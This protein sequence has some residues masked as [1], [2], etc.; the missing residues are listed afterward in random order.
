[1]ESNAVRLLNIITAYLQ[2]RYWRRFGSRLELESH[3]QNLWRKQQ[4]R[5]TKDSPLYRAY[6]DKKLSDFPIMNKKDMMDNFDNLNTKSLKKSD[7]L[8][9]ALK[10]EESRDFSP[11]VGQ[12]SVGL[13]S[14]T[15]GNRGLFLADATERARWAGI[16]LAKAL[17]KPLP[18]AQKI[19]LFLRANNNLYTTLTSK[20][21]QFEFFD[22]QDELTNH[23]QRLNQYRPSI[24]VS[25]PSMLRM[26]A[27]EAQKGRLK[28]N[29]LRIFSAAEVLDPID[30]AYISH[31]FKQKVH[32]LYQ[33]TEGFLG[34][35]CAHGTIHL[36][37][38]FVIVEKEWID[39]A[40]RK[41]IPIITD[42]ERHTQPIVRYRLND[43]LTERATPCP[44]GSPHI[45]LEQIEGRADD[46]FY[47]KTKSGEH[48]AVFPDYLRRRILQADD[49]IEEYSLRQHN[50]DELE[51]RLKKGNQNA[52]RE[53][54]ERFFT[55]QNI[56]APAL[57][58]EM[59]EDHSGTRKM[60]RVERLFSPN[61]ADVI[62]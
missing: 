49:A 60:K 61:I 12:V 31:V 51:I 43:V 4:A 7:C 16:I 9:V 21:I 23:V 27:T 1:M 36:N 28:I 20:K 52:V 45:A 10:S 8:D 33:C 26:L 50:E 59:Y 19:A 38:D 44:C 55:E 40:K 42:L 46:I 6:A 25:P 54:F 29:P 58:F 34:A 17:P 39:K 11:M 41:F 35:S 37:E 13:S 24:L 48:K 18:L 62:Q 47:F 32:Q 14:G 57:R 22:L 30:E 2:T 3:Q 53:Q 5:I 56:K 15:S